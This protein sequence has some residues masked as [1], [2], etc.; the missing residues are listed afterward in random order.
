MG[1]FFVVEKIVFFS[2]TKFKFISLVSLTEWKTSEKV[3]KKRE[4]PGKEK[5]P[6]EIEIDSTDDE[7]THYN[8]S[9]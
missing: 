5:K 9:L 7:S 4:E 3:Q 6:R 2:E 1:Y 8:N